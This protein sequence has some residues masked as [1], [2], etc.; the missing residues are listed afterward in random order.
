MG[1]NIEVLVERHGEQDHKTVKRKVKIR[2]IKENEIRKTGKEKQINDA[3]KE[4]EQGK[5]R[6]E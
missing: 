3:E 2:K 4:V 6:K 5:Q 1:K